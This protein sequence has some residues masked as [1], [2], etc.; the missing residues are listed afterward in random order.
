[1]TSATIT[2]DPRTAQPPLPTTAAPPSSPVAVAGKS[3]DTTTRDAIIGAV[4]GG[5]VVLI[6]IIFWIVVC[7][8]KRRRPAPAET[9]KSPDQA[10]LAQYYD[11]GGQ[12]DYNQQLQGAWGQAPAGLDPDE[13]RRRHERLREW[14]REQ[15]RYLQRQ[16]EERLTAQLEQAEEDYPEFVAQ[17]FA[18]EPFDFDRVDAFQWGTDGDRRILRVGQLDGVRQAVAPG[19]V[20]G[21]PAITPERARWLELHGFERVTTK[22]GGFAYASPAFT[23]VRRDRPLCAPS[24]GRSRQCFQRD[25]DGM[26]L[27]ADA[28][29]VP[30]CLLGAPMLSVHPLSGATHRPQVVGPRHPTPA[31]QG[32][33]AACAPASLAGSRDGRS[34]QGARGASSRGYPGPWGPA[35][36]QQLA[37]GRAQDR[38]QGAVRAGA[39]RGGEGEGV[40]RHQAAAGGARCAG[41]LRAASERAGAAQAPSSY[42]TG[43]GAGSGSCPVPSPGSCPCAGRCAAR[44]RS[45]GVSPAL[46]AQ[47]GC[48]N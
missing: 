47:A 9:P 8:Y 27:T 13:E 2:P 45:G 48:V 46:A 36:A 19:I 28:M 34:G 7:I 44:S 6:I 15:Q 18:H 43:T 17:H 32:A 16:E 29:P 31:A 42:S 30:V 33:T 37:R 35:S 24:L 39:R 25:R 40:R 10:K 12:Y 23:E 1:M 3:K 20:E 41:V 38:G 11:N 22:D 4:V 26:K 21:F 5:G 14:E